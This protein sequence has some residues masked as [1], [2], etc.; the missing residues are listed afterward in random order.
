MNTKQTQGQGSKTYSQNVV[1]NIEKKARTKERKAMECPEGSEERAQ[2]LRER[3]E[4][5]D[6]AAEMKRNIAVNAKNKEK[7]DK[8]KRTDATKSDDQ[9]MNE[10]MKWNKQHRNEGEKKMMDEYIKNEVKRGRRA[11]AQAMREEKKKK[12][13]EEQ[14]QHL[15]A[16][17]DNKVMVKEE[18]ESFAKE[19]KEKHPDAN[20]S[21]IQKEFVKKAMQDAHEQRIKMFFIH[22]M[23]EIKE[24]E[25]EKVYEEYNDIH[26]EFMERP[27]IK[28]RMDAFHSTKREE[29]LDMLEEEMKVIVTETNCRTEFVKHVVMMTGDKKENVEKEY[30]DDYE[31]FKVYAEGQGFTRS[32]TIDKYVDL[33]NKKLQAAQFR[34]KIVSAMMD[35]KNMSVDEA[36]D[37]FD[38]MMNAAQN[39]IDPTEPTC[40]PCK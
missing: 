17:E 36:N 9:L 32:V 20:D 1:R 16:I 13:E 10:A 2:Y 33:S 6:L 22:N 28:Q 23:S 34:Y 4:C 15:Q 35:D 14:E 11:A 24:E 7:K 18:K 3:D 12:M 30:D 5:N 27:E 38:K 31:K 21:E 37:E 40:L 26:K 8:K 25:P 19:Y 39:T 29:V